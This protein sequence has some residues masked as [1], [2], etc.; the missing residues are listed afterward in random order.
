MKKI[1]IGKKPEYIHLGDHIDPFLLFEK[2]EQVFVTCFLFESL[3]ENGSMARFSIIGFDPEYIVCGEKTELIINRTRYVVEN[4][5]MMLHDLIPQD[6]LTRNYAGG[7]VG[8][9][10]YDAAH[11]FE[12][13]LQIKHNTHFKP[14]VFGVYTDGIIYDKVTGESYYFYFNVNRI[15]VVKKILKKEKKSKNIYIKKG[16]DSLQR[17]DHR[18][19]VDEV[20]K[21][22][23]SGN[24][25][26]CQIGIKKEFSLRGDPI[27]LYSRLRNVNPSPFMYFIKFDEKKIIGASPELLFGMRNNEMSTFPLAGT[28]KRGRSREEDRMLAKQLLHNPKEIA[29]HNM[30]V[31]LHRN[32]I[33]KVARFGS[34]KIRN[35]KDVKKFSHVQHISSEIVGL[36]RNEEDMFSALASNFPAGTLSGAPKI[37]SMRIIEKF[38][39]TTRG[40]Y[41]GAVGHFGFNG[42]CTF[43]IPIRTIF[44]D[45]DYGFTMAASGIVYDSNADKEYEEIQQKLAAM[46]EVLTI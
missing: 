18:I 42:D 4:P 33:G 38:E 7:L 21:E 34:V 14:F 19:I 3:G 9:I 16:R 31:D 45:A 36:L 29:E 20:K 26:Q 2:I 13:S 37:E 22:I 11:F 40:P 41:G 23:V 46:C 27:V 12:P 32:D 30:L 24:T 8:Y 10:G 28:N 15:S 39:G 1:L 6:S 5:Y 17:I 43:A 35:L 25:F 44:I